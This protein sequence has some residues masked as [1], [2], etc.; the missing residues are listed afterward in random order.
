MPSDK[1]R[2]W[3]DGFRVVP[4]TPKMREKARQEHFKKK[5]LARWNM[6]PKGTPIKASD[7]YYVVGK[8]SSWRRISKD[9]FQKLS[10]KRSIPMD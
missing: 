3:P 9:E 10:Q 7:R 8:D 6:Y 1:Y 4:M 2:A 5:A